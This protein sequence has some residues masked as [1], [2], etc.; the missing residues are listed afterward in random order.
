LFFRIG[1]TAY[2]GYVFAV[3]GD[4]EYGAEPSG[5][6]STDVMD[7]IIYGVLGAASGGIINHIK[8]RSYVL[9]YKLQDA[10]RIDQLTNMNNRNSFE[11]DLGRY[12]SIVKESLFCIYIDVNGLH[13]LNNSKGHLQGDIMLQFIA[14]RMR[15]YF[16]DEYTYRIGGDEFVAFVPDTEE[17]KMVLRI[18]K[19]NSEIE[20]EGYHVA[21]GFNAMKKE[22]LIWI[23]S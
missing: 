10:S 3:A 6:L 13:E 22:T 14:N 15:D 9:E 11:S 12:P 16:G 21:I 19:L 18:G 1:N 23:R 20:R 5:V 8:V 7:A 17:E 2:S 4:T